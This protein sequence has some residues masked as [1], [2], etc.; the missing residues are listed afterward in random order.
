MNLRRVTAR[1][2]PRKLPEL[3]GNRDRCGWPLTAQPCVWMR[4]YRGMP[5][6][7]AWCVGRFESCWAHH[8][9]MA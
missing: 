2:I 9:Q 3:T 7:A 5:I 4:D 8:Q 6:D 1:H